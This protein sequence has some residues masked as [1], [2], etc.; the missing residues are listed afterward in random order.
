[1]IFISI[2]LRFFVKYYNIEICIIF[3]VKFLI[4]LGVV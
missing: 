4:V 2:K 3:Y 1:M